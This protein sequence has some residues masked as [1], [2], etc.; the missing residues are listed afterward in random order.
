M[1]DRRHVHADREHETEHRVPELDVGKRTAT[2]RL[3]HR[4]REEAFADAVA[5]LRR[6]ILRA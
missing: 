4:S 3:P 6:Y 2:Q 5:T 1:F